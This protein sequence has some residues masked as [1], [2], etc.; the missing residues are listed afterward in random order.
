MG[1]WGGFGMR[2]AKIDEKF[3]GKWRAAFRVSG[4]CLIDKE[5]PTKGRGKKIKFVSF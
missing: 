3:L 5:D 2:S 1:E 4:A